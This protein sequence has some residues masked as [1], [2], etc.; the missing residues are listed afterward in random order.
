MKKLS[1]KSQSAEVL[2]IVIVVLFVSGLLMMLSY[3]I[4]S[5]MTD[6]FDD[7]GFDQSVEAGNRFLA[8]LRF[9]DYL[10]VILLVILIIGVGIS[11][12]KISVSPVFVIITVLFVPIYG[13]ISYFFNFVFAE[14]VRNP[15]VAA[16]AVNYPRTILICTNLHW[17]ML[18]TVVVGMITLFGKKE[19]GQFLA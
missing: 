17:V 15:L 19:K 9:M 5:E 4:V 7:A 2:L 18:I 13:F 3:L 10:M 12:I 1:K 8:G 11:S 16:I 6:A 14:F